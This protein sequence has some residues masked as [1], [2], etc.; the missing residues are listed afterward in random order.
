VER[1]FHINRD[2]QY[3]Q[4]PVVEVRAYF[5]KRT[6][7]LE[8]KERAM[9][10]KV[11]RGTVILILAALLVPS[12]SA[13][14]SPVVR[15]LDISV[16]YQESEEQYVLCATVTTG[17]TVMPEWVLVDFTGVTR[18]ALVDVDGVLDH[19]TDESAFLQVSNL[20]AA[21]DLAS[22]LL[23]HRRTKNQPFTSVCYV[24]YS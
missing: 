5:G 1:F 8:S 14:Q 16:S 23:V 10:R 24:T 20:R 22:L 3:I 21:P 6:Q 7:E 13:A 18:S 12:L 9:M 4:E 15:G 19:L 17:A 2:K 11:F